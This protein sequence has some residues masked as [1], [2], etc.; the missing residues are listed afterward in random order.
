MRVCLGATRT[1]PA[2]HVDGCMDREGGE[3]DW[4]CLGTCLSWEC[5]AVEHFSGHSANLMK[6]WDEGTW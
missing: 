2:T 4:V 5:R 1:A 6:D 3:W